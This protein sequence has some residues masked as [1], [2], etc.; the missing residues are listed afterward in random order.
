MPIELVIIYRLL[1]RSVPSLRGCR[2]RSGHGLDQLHFTVTQGGPILIDSDLPDGLIAFVSKNARNA[3]P[4]A[5][6]VLVG[7][8]RF[9]GVTQPQQAVVSHR[10]GRDLG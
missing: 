3:L 8:G 10:A 9:L 4:A 2:E 1:D 7:F 6:G 5:I